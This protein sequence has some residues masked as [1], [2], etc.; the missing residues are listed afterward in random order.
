MKRNDLSYNLHID[1]KS[2]AKVKKAR[3]LKKQPSVLERI[4]VVENS[5]RPGIGLFVEKILQGTTQPLVDTRVIDSEEIAGNIE[6]F[7]PDVVILDVD[8]LRY[9]N[10]LTIAL[11]MRKIDSAQV[12]VFMSE[13]ANPVLVKEGMVAALWSRAYWLNQPSRNPAMVLPE[14]LQ[15]F[16]GKQQ[17]NPAVLE[18]AIDNTTHFGL[19]S[20][21]QHRVMR[22]M[23]LGGSNASIARNCSL[24]I[25]AVE[26]T[27]ATAS[28]LLEVEPA[29]ADTNHRVKAANRYLNLMLF[30]DSIGPL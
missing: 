9:F 22:L 14:I 2:S 16:N 4:L 17:L 20:P 28:K 10:A 3:P 5:F 7:H 29:S 21:Q 26:R 12:V 6:S 18:A 30:A 24:S 13:R 1:K 11:D 19:L 15:A 27:I 25:K 23:A 8:S